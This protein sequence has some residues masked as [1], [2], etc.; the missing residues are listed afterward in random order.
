[1]PPAGELA[2]ADIFAR[3]LDLTLLRGRRRGRVRCIFHQDR[4]ASLSVDLDA[5]LFH[6]FGCGAQGGVLAF[7]VLVGERVPPA[8]E[9]EPTPWAVAMQI[10]R[11]QPWYRPAVRDV[12]AISDWIRRTRRE[13]ARL[14]DLP[15]VGW[16]MLAAVADLETTANA[17]EAELD[18]IYATGPLP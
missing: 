13:V 10:A 8:P 6:C 18:A 9:I 11:A 1:M 5:G 4:T 12:Y 7:A 17:A 14:R 15:D 3:H 16:E 2:M